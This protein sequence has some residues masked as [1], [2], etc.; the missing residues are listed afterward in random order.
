MVGPMALILDGNSQH[1]AHVSRKVFA[2]KIRFLTGSRSNQ[3]PLTNL[4][5][6]IAP[7]V[8]A[9]ISEIP[10]NIS[11]IDSPHHISAIAILCRKPISNQYIQSNILL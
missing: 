2:E 8:K 3:M 1:A 10:S 5:T 9:P 4:I 11:A 6:E 7:C